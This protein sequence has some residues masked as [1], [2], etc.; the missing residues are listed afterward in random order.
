MSDDWVQC[1]ICGS[2]VGAGAVAD[3]DRAAYETGVQDT[4]LRATQYE[5][6]LLDLI[7]D[8]VGD[9]G[10]GHEL[11]PGD[12]GPDSCLVCGYIDRAESRLEGLNDV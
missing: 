10:D 3:Y 6:I 5:R 9:D 12:D 8:L 1:P 4:T 11:T 2:D 7:A